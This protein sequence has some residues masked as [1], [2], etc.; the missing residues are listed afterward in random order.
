M[1][2]SKC[3][4]ELIENIFV[5]DGCG[6]VIKKPKS[7]SI[8]AIIF[9][10]AAVLSVFIGLI[11]IFTPTVLKTAVK[12]PLTPSQE[13]TY[14][15]GAWIGVA[16]ILW[17]ILDFIIGLGLNKLKR[18]AG[19]LGIIESSIVLL[20]AIAIPQF[21]DIVNYIVNILVIIL[22]SYGRKALR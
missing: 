8:A 13:F 1:F 6:R 15:Y 2:C 21:R 16:L 7:I 11:F 17:G 4:E 12:S 20:L 9:I 19:I 5:C 14:R 3:G 22:I 10:I 18:W